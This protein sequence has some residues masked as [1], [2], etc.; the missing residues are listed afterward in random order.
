ME[1]KLEKKRKGNQR[2]KKN[3]KNKSSFSDEI[4][5]H[6]CDCEAT[7]HPLVN[8]CM[9]CGRIVCLSEGP[10]PCFFCGNIV[11]YENEPLTPI[12]F[13][14][15]SSDKGKQVKGKVY[16]ND[17]YES[18]KLRDKLIEYDKN[19]ASRTSVIDDESDYYQANNT[20]LSKEQREKWEK[21]QA[22]IDDE[23]HK[24]RFN[25]KLE[26]DFT[27]RVFEEKKDPLDLFHQMNAIQDDRYLNYPSSNL[28]NNSHEIFKGPVYIDNGCL[29]SN[30]VEDLNF[31]INTRVQD[32]GY[33]EIT[34]QGVCL[35]M[36]QPYAS[37]LVRGI[38]TTEGRTWYTSHRGRLWIAAAAKDP[39]KEEIE[40]IEN[41]YKMLSNKNIEFPKSYPTSC[42]LGCV[43]VMDVLSQ[44]E[45]D[46]LHPDNHVNS[47][48]I[49][50]C[51][52]FFEL[53]LKYPMPG[54]HKIFK[55][56]PVL[57]RAAVNCLEKTR[58]EIAKNAHSL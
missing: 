41:T 7:K 23:K 18:M 19:C 26:M 40:T 48:Y 56:D 4:V 51:E 17:S 31:N 8:N 33:L 47:P 32:K 42:L 5:R 45:Y 13:T 29:P 24:S 43:T 35:S 46:Q 55:L 25:R 28:K 50:I 15:D 9:N 20:W 44:E 34:D 37:L 11:C 27:G 3:P 14:K 49:F 52:D 1:I 12:K 57:H 2:G 10:G 36:H 6:A 54:K 30:P 39:S 21:L 16:S 58:K 53:P 38:K 22:M